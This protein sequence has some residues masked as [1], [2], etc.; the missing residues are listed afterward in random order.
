MENNKKYRLVITLNALNHLGINLYSNVPAVL[1][2][3]V[4][5]AWDADAEK[6]KISIDRNLN[7]IRIKDTGIGMNLDDINEKYLKVGYRKRDNGETKTPILNRPVMGRK[8]IGKLSLFSIAETIEVYSKKGS[9]LNAFRM[10]T[11]DIQNQISSDSNTKA[12]YPEEIS[13]EPINFD[14]GTLLIL[15]GITKR[16]YQN[17]TEGALKK[18]L[19]RRFSIIGEKYKFRVFINGEEIKIEDRDYFHKI[20]YLW[21]YGDESYKEF[22][23]N[24]IEI[25]KRDNLLKPYLKYQKPNSCKIEGE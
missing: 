19:S 6:V 10:N 22:A 18:R 7:E 23:K 2:E 8:G 5:N 15:K 21:Y 12:Y 4:A 14:K 24:A 20:E 25:R 16:L 1:S 13:T 9:S 3:V 11:K 17:Q